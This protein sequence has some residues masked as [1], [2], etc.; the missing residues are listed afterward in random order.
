MLLRIC[1]K[2]GMYSLP[3]L[4]VMQ[5]MRSSCTYMGRESGFPGNAGGY[6]SL[7]ALALVC[8]RARTPL[9]QPC[10]VTDFRYTRILIATRGHTSIHV[11]TAVRTYVLPVYLQT[12]RMFDSSRYL[13]TAHHDKSWII[14]LVWIC[15][16]VHS[17]RLQVWIPLG[18]W[19]SPSYECGVLSERGLCEG[20]IPRP[21]GSYW[22]CESLSVIGCNNNPLYVQWVGRRGKTKKERKIKRNSSLHNNNNN[23]NN[24][25]T[26]RAPV[27]TNPGTSFLGIRIGQQTCS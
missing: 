24:E 3:L 14:T 20:P 6:P 2:Y 13:S 23:N 22:V 8:S 10:Y 9:R 12:C 21:E 26:Y 11:V 16:N 25:T 17:L 1:S 27:S 18:V 7:L 15:H 5:R 4:W 19:M